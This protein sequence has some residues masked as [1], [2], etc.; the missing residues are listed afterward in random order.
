LRFLPIADQPP[1]LVALAWRRDRGGD[2]AIE[3]VVRLALD[4][5]GAEGA[6][7]PLSAHA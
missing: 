4:A 1:R 6:Q 7:P 3:R 2:D 5:A